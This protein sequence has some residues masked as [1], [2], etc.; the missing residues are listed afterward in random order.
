MLTADLRFQR[1]LED[2]SILVEPRYSL[3]RFSDTRFGNGDNRSLTSQWQRA[4]ERA[5]VSFNASIADQSTL[6]TEL[7]E[8]G[9]VGLDVHQRQIQGDGSWKWSIA[10]TRQLFAE[11]S[12][13]DVHY[14]G[15]ANIDQVLP[16]YQY[17]A[18]S[19][20]EM[21]TLSEQT[22]ISLSAFGNNISSDAAGNSSHEYGVQ[23]QLTYA[24]SERTRFVGS[25]GRS[26]RVLAGQSSN[27]TDF[28]ATFVRDVTLGSISLSY[29][30]SLVPFGAGFFEERKQTAASFARQLAPQVHATL[31]YTRTRNNEF[32]VLL[33]NDRPNYDIVQGG[34]DWRPLENWAVGV[35]LASVHSTGAG[36]FGQTQTVNEWR[37][38]VYVNWTPRPRVQSW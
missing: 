36:F 27:G 14:H 32:A 34:L 5:L 35:Q 9:I 28:S 31:S 38:S 26:Q 33:S 22:Q 23:A 13:S 21:F 10:Q 24:W 8:T 6:T 7:L 18:V 11:V 37:S 4:W 25:L 29:V 19:L 12:D 3:R 16:G 20:G 1:A 17:R 2:S 15:V 30:R